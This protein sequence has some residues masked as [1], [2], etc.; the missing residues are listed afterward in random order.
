MAQTTRVAT[1]RRRERGERTW[2]LVSAIY[3]R[4]AGWEVSSGRLSI[5]I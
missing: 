3:S 4:T 1:L 2:S 5:V